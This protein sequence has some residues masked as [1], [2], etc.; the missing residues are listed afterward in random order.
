MKRL[1]RPKSDN[2]KKIRLEIKLTQSESNKLQKCAETL[3]TSK[4][5]VVLRGIDLVEAELDKINK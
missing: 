3:Q 5:A 2:P 1:G 4:S